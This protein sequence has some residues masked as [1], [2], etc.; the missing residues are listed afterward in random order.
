KLK[1]VAGFGNSPV[2][3]Y[4]GVG[5]YFLDRISDGVWRLEVQ[6]DAVWVDNPFGRNSFDKTVGVIKW[7]T[8]Q[9]TINLQNLGTDFAIET[10]NDDNAFET[11]TSGKSFS[12]RPGTYI[13]SKAGVKKTWKPEDGF[14]T[15]KLKDFYAP[16]TTVDKSY[17]KH[18][19]ISEISEG[20]A[21]KIEVQYVAPDTPETI[22]VV[23]YS[24]RERFN[25]E[26]KKSSAYLYEGIIP[27]DK[28][29]VGYLNYNIIVKT[30]D[31]YRTF[32]ADKE[33][34]PFEWNFY[35]RETYKVAVVPSTN[36]IQLFDA[37]ED[38]DLL[39][40]E[41]RN[42]FKLVPTSNPKEAEYQMNIEKLFVVDE[43]NLN[44]EPI[45]DYT[46]KHFVT[47]RI[48]GRKE[49]LSSKKYIVFKGRALN[50]KPCN[51]QIALVMDDGTSY[52]NVIEIGTETE[53]YRLAISELKPVKTVTLPRPYP[54]FLPYY[55][56]HNIKG[57]FDI[58]RIES[59]QFSLGPEISLEDL[60]SPHGV[61][62]I[63]VSFE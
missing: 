27:S 22:Q 29:S 50:D 12:I 24:G 16:K 33:G 11:K 47:D 43:E 54:S 62:I 40:K 6:P 31:N 19:P 38:S 57:D 1:E 13:L 59:I 51:L 30:G 5:A 53:D 21:L 39:V 17:L 7:E 55:L 34:R 60:E 4:D 14:R 2:V 35:D 42:S 25:I 3:A 26:M 58:N 48:E 9:M 46:F 18:E 8:H 37:L 23:G 32:P 49:D 52:G 28:I 45:Y 36:T 10:I 20:S 56:E 61:S 63:S 41:W 15:N 44:S